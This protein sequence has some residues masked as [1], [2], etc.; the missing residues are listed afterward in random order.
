MIDFKKRKKINKTYFQVA[1]VLLLLLLA[2]FL[3]WMP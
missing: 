2:V 3:L 1:G